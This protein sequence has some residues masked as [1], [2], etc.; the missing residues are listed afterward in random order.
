MLG[1]AWHGPWAGH[2]RAA[3]RSRTA[4]LKP[5]PG[6]E[7]AV[8]AALLQGQPASRLPVCWCEM[9]EMEARPTGATAMAAEPQ[10]AA[11]YVQFITEEEDWLGRKAGHSPGDPRQGQST[12]AEERPTKAP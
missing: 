7:R 12:S 2:L 11:S 9:R 4:S 3:F 10:Q 1:A 6:W 8:Q 5:G